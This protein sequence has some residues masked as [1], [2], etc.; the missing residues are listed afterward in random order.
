MSSPHNAVPLSLSYY[1]VPELTPP[2]AV[3]VAAETGCRFVGMRLLHGQPGRDLL[4]IM[5][6]AG[7]R[8][9]TLR[10]LCDT[11][12]QV[13]DANSAR[14]LPETEVA[15][16]RPFLEV[17]AELGARHILASADDPDAARLLERFAA[18]CDMASPFGLTV[19]IEFVPWMAIS[20]LTRAVEIMRG[21]GKNN[22]GIA[23]DAL[24]FDRSRSRL[25]DLAAIPRDRLRYFQICDAPADRG[26]DRARLIHIATKERLLPGEGAID[27]VGLLRHLPR[28]IPV[29]LEIPLAEPRRSM[30]ARERVARAVASTLRV[31]E[32]AYGV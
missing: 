8:R 24:H 22:L 23:V 31:L 2:E 11:G 6:D 18:L 12:I 32:A 20:N 29:A 17:A 10:T 15:A 19:D 7:L 5:L 28:R 13:L 14:L 25:L 1:T 30:P 4:P 3:R 9:E 16:F 27:L 26:D 21:A